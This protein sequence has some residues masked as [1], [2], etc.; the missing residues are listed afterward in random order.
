MISNHQPQ[1]LG[2]YLHYPDER[3]PDTVR[4]WNVRLI[5]LQRELRHLDKTAM[6]Q[7]YKE[8]DAFLAMRRCE[9]E[10]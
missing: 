1:V 9:L 4:S 6:L 8:L 5:P 3:P 7:L 2:V 10:Y